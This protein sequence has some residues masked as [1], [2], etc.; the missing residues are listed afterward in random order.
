MMRT[1]RPGY[2]RVVRIAPLGVQFRDVLD[3]RVVADGLRVDLLDAERPAKAVRLRA[4]PS[5]VF[6]AHALPGMNGF[7][8]TEVTSPAGTSN[9]FSLSVRD[10]LG[11][12]VDARIALDFPNEGLFEPICLHESPSI[13]SPPHVPLYSAAT[14]PLPAALAVVRADLRIVQEDRQPKTQPASWAWIELWLD[15]TRLATGVADAN[16][17]VLLL[18]PLPTPREPTRRTSPPASFERMAWNV[19]LRAYWNPGHRAEFVPDICD[20]HTQP[21]VTLLQDRLL[22]APLASLQLCAGEPLIVA[23]AHSPFLLIA[24]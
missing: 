20:I 16:G 7:D 23:S 5:G 6:V 12:F 22:S 3:R 17:S 4:S 19:S 10:A 8:A 24:P 1:L 2:D 13:D 14:R 9:R 18:C 15:T 21:E 11:R